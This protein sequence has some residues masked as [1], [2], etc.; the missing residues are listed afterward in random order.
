MGKFAI[1]PLHPSNTFFSQF[2]N[3]LAYRTKLE[4]PKSPMGADA[5][6]SSANT[7]T[8]ASIRGEA[9]TDRFGEASAITWG[10]A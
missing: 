1:I 7:R 4:S 2:P 3:C 8:R 9:T 10:Q 5:R 6:T